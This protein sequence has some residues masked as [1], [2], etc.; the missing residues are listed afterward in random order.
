MVVDQNAEARGI[1]FARSTGL[2]AVVGD[3]PTDRTLRRAGVD[4]AL[5]LVCATSSDMVNLETALQARAMRGQDLRIV[6]RL[7]DDDLAR[8][9]G[10]NLPNVVSRSVSYL[11]APAFAAAM[12]EHKVLRTIAVGRHVLLIADVRV[13]ADAAI[14]ARPLADL[15][16]DGQARVLALASLGTARFSWSPRRDQPLAAGDRLIVLATRAGLSTF[17]ASNQPL[18]RYSV[19]QDAVFFDQERYER[20]RRQPTL[21]GE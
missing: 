9:V 13:E 4:S 19:T 8:R 12:L 14:A 18:G 7:F 11:A 2:P 5:A 16:R 1:A 3:S 21:D 20:D 6:L 17:L 15:E 10:E